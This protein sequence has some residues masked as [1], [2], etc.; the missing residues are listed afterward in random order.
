MWSLLIQNKSLAG[1]YATTRDLVYTQPKTELTLCVLWA[2]AGALEAHLFA[3][4]HTGVAGQQAGAFEGGAHCHIEV[5]EGTSNAMAHSAALTRHTATK[6]LGHHIEAT[7]L[8]GGF[9][10]ASQF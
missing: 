7:D 1:H 3:L 2:L 8:A 9:E 10:W 4:F 6:H 5:E